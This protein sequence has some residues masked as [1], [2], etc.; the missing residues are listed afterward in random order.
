VSLKTKRKISV[1]LV[2]TSGSKLVELTS[3]ELITFGM[4]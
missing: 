4:N 2:S 3:D 1:S